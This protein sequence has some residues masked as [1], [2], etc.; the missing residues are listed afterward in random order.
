MI[1]R[2]RKESG[3][4]VI[5]EDKEEMFIKNEEQSEVVPTEWLLFLG[6]LVVLE[7]V[8]VPSNSDRNVVI[9]SC[10]ASQFSFAV[11]EMM[12]LISFSHQVEKG[13]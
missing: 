13:R 9:Q 11:G 1:V 8:Y 10:D 7:Y 6:A 2:A 4:K 3:N 12:R 5:V